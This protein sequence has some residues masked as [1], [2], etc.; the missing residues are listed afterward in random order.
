MNNRTSPKSS[1]LFR[2]VCS[3]TIVFV[4][5]SSF[6]AAAYLYT[7]YR[8][9]KKNSEIACEELNEAFY[10]YYQDLLASCK[11]YALKI[12]NTNYLD[13]Q[14]GDYRINR[15]I[16]EQ[17]PYYAYRAIQTLGEYR[18]GLNNIA[19][20]GIYFYGS[21]YVLTDSYK[22]DMNDYLAVMSANQPES[23][24]KIYSFFSPGPIGSMHM[25]STFENDELQN[26]KL[27]IGVS[28]HFDTTTDGLFFF[29]VNKDSLDIQRL[30]DPKNAVTHYYIY[31][32]NGQLCFANAPLPGS[33]A[34]TAVATQKI[35][36]G[37]E[38]SFCV[39]LDQREFRF[40]KKEYEFSQQIFLV[41]VEQSQLE[42]NTENFYHSF[43]CSFLIVLAVLLLLL[44][45][46][47][48]IAYH[49]VRQM[50]DK[51]NH[52]LPF[53]NKR[54]GE[55]DTI[56]QAFDRMDWTVS[57]Q[58]TMV[59]EY[60][61]FTLI[62]HVAM[63]DH[64]VELCPELF[65]ASTYCVFTCE[66]LPLS[67]PEREKICLSATKSLDTRIYVVDLLAQG[68]T[69]F[70]SISP[71]SVLPEEI[72]KQI[73]V[74]LERCFSRPISLGCGETVH[75]IDDIYLSYQQSVLSLQ[76]QKE[77]PACSRQY[78]EVETGL[79]ESLETL[80]HCVA[81]QDEASALAVLHQ[82]FQCVD[83]NQISRAYKQYIHYTILIGYLNGVKQ[84]VGKQETERLI[85]CR[86]L[87]E[88]FAL[89]QSSIHTICADNRKNIC[90]SYGKLKSEI[91][92]YVEQHFTD[93]EICRTQVADL[94]GISIYSFSRLFKEATG[95]GFKE[96]LITKKME[97]AREKILTTDQ[98]LNQI[99]E[100]VGFL[101]AEHFSK[102][103]KNYF[104]VAPSHYRIQQ[105]NSLS[106]SGIE[107]Q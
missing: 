3:L 9:I 83:S 106:G 18:N 8:N 68:T 73:T 99:A 41:A 80:I 74:E 66:S 44:G 69:V 7:T 97:L 90:T 49:P 84:N 93:P 94:F 105:Q 70:F 28:V 11:N 19:A 53:P 30:S 51:I 45:L 71:E 32:A 2:I 79:A 17:N 76:K 12:S 24:E 33:A 37:S 100:E 46:T 34:E 81:L 23:S 89:M 35:F 55:I 50:V 26:G 29:V 61:I 88:L 10:L 91:T 14:N 75:N 87:N 39:S 107:L 72:F 104:G 54:N 43:I 48:Y 6:F 102:M 47:G 16:I 36:S 95:C 5:I 78:L 92:Q 63:P 101:N 98:N 38:D 65:E 86:N 56:L 15:A 27:L 22:Y 82:L 13:S 20:L 103:F 40:F 21:N 4:L 85:A 58:R 57:E 1:Y 96:Y 64:A 42:Q 52:H 62:N 25:V 60:L 59:R 77:M 31:N 67:S